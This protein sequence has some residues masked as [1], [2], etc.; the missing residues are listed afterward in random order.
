MLLARPGHLGEERLEGLGLAV[1]DECGQVRTGGGLRFVL[2]RLAR[3]P[4]RETMGQ[5]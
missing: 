4:D 3:L 5:R 1:T 2:C